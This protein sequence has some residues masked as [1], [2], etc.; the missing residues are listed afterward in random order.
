VHPY[1]ISALVLSFASGIALLTA[2]LDTFLVSKVF[3]LKM[4]L[5]LLLLANGA[6]MRRLENALQRVAEGPVNGT[7]VLR[8]S[9]LWDRLRMVAIVSLLLW[10]TIT[11]T[12]VALVNV[13]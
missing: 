1:V 8:A 11:F 13:S 12:G 7:N 5:V 2:D 9:T 6:V 10:L 3:W 4:G